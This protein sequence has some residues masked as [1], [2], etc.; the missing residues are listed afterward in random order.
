MINVGLADDPNAARTLEFDVRGHNAA[1]AKAF[2]RTAADEGLRK[3]SGTRRRS[4][5]AARVSGPEEGQLG[6]P[7][8]LT[9][10]PR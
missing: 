1:A 7:C 10:L 2:F 3:A 4:A 6:P 5:T 9:S 8:G